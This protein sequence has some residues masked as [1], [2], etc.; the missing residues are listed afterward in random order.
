VG[1]IKGDGTYVDS[2]SAQTIGSNY[3]GGV[4]IG[5]EGL[6]DVYGFMME[7]RLKKVPRFRKRKIKFVALGIGYVHI[8]N[9]VDC[10]LEFYDFK[11]PLRYRQKQN[12]NFAGDLT[13]QDNPEF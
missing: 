2:T 10:D 9:Q 8:E 1:T 11:M 5:G 13:D 12:V 7:I 4:A 3:I 6:T